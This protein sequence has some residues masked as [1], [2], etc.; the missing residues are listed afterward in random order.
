MKIPPRALFR[1]QIWAT[2]LSYSLQISN[3]TISA[4]VNI[5][6]MDW[7]LANIKDICSPNQPNHFTCPGAQVFFT[8]SVIWGAI[9]PARIFSPGQLYYPT[10]WFF[11]LGALLPVPFYFLS[12][13]RPVKGNWI[14]Y[15]N[16]PL[17]FGSMDSLPPATPMNYASWIILK[18]SLHY[19]CVDLL[20]SFSIFGLNGGGEVGGPNTIIFWYVSKSPRDGNKLIECVQSAGLDVGLAVSTLFIFFVRFPVHNVHLTIFRYSPFRESTFQIGGVRT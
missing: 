3:L 2:L 20:V 18:Y 19:S 17:I 9:G 12:R 6:V 1:T 13:S 15:I 16:I 8:A 14:R 4:F 10:L 7:A 11:L 5:M